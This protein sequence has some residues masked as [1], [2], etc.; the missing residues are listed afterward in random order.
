[1][2]IRPAGKMTPL[3]QQWPLR[4]PVAECMSVSSMSL[5]D[6][7]ARGW[8]RSWTVGNCWSVLGVSQD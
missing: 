3:L 5:S 1:M 7:L 4:H 6:C 2:P 8:I